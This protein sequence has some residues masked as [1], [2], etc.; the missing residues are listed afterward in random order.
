MAQQNV[1][2]AAKETQESSTFNVN[3]AASDAAE[4]LASAETGQAYTATYSPDDNK[5][6]L[7][8]LL[9]LDEETYARVKAAGFRWAPKQELFVAPMWTPARED[10]L[11]ELAGDIEDEDQSLFSRQ[12]E[13]AERFEDYSDKRAADSARELDAVERLTSGIPLGQPILVGHHSERRAR[14]AAQR[15]E[16]GM[17]RAVNLFETAEYWQDRAAAALRHASYKEQ[18]A[19]RW[20]RIKKIEADLRKAEKEISGAEKFIKAWAADG[21]TPSRALSIANYDHVSACFTLDK[22]PRPADKSQ[23]EGRMSL[24]SA[25]TDEIIT[26]EQAREISTRVRTRSIAHY[27]RWAAHYRNRLAYERA[28][29]DESGSILST[30]LEMEAGGMVQSRGEWLQILRVNRSGGKISS[31]V[32]AQYAFMRMPGREMSLTPDRITDYQ[33]PDREAA[34]AAKLAAKRP[35]IVNYHAEGFRTMTKAE[36]AKTPGDYK[37]VRGVAGTDDHKP[38]RVR[39]VMS[40]GCTLLQVYIS[41]A[42]TVEIPR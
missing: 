10:L 42:K 37:A 29:L 11:I 31:V 30:S 40:S 24:Y 22:Y 15:V 8:A 36:W 20:R 32:T 6:R 2:T 1:N 19:V 23:H 27:Q 16:N 18:P 39:R 13:R 41:D 34:A 28:M 38:H 33:A 14:R 25:L 26:P 7:Y 21:L 3:T 5:L 4:T 35:P 12:E 9:R 17:R